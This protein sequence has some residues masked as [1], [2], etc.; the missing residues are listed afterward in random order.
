[1]KKLLLRSLLVLTGTLVAIVY[2]YFPTQSS[3]EETVEIPFVLER[4]II[5][6]N[7][8]LNGQGPYNMVLDTGTDPSVVDSQIADEISWL[9]IPLGA[10]GSSG[11]SDQ[12]E[13]KL[14]P[15][16]K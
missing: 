10:Q 14:F 13:I 11:A 9:Q 3:V 5:I 1:M 4:D 8:M 15:R 6:V 12:I 2:Y 16:L 7:A